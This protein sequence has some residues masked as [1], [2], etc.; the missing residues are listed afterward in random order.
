MGKGC[1][2]FKKLEDLALDLVGR[3]VARVPVGKHGQLTGWQERSW[4]A[5]RGECWKNPS[6]CEELTPI[7]VTILKRA[8]TS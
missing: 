5:R 8:K 2:R 1:V 3:T 4:P 7:F 6:Q